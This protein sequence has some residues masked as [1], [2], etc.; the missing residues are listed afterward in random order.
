MVVFVVIT[1]CLVPTLTPFLWTW[2]NNWNFCYPDYT[3]E[4][5]ICC[6][7][8]SVGKPEINHCCVMLAK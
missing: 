8:K 7:N 1:V 6:T 2:P 3:G 5:N 4:V